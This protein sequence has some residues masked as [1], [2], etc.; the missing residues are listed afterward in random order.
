MQHMQ[1]LKTVKQCQ[2]YVAQLRCHGAS[3]GIVPTMGALHEGHLS[4]VRQSNRICDHTIASIFVNPTQFSA[5]EDL[6]QYPR[7]L[8]QDLELLSS[9]GTRAVF[10]PDPEEMYPPGHSTVVMA[11]DVARVLE[12]EY[13]PTH[14]EGVTTIVLKLF[15]TLPGTHAFFGKKDFQQLCVIQAMVRDLNLTIDIVPC[16][17]VR[18]PDGLAMSSRNR[19]LDA[20]Q[21]NR[22]AGIYRSL[23]AIKSA[24]DAGQRST[25]ALESSLKRHVTGTIGL[26]RRRLNRLCKSC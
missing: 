19:Y 15:H 4:L 2:A 6:D 5:D 20:D 22:A 21:R 13:R 7:T 12:G 16:E 14:F 9:N 11:G 17:I 1:V 26:S 25:A 23:Q 10:V 3:V 8:G 18:E 24:F